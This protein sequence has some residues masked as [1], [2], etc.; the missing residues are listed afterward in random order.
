MGSLRQAVRA[1]IPFSADIYES[2]DRH[3]R[4]RRA[5]P[6]IDA[7]AAGTTPIKLDLGGGYRKGTNG[8]TTVDISHECDLFWDLRH[9]IPFADGTVAA[10]YSSHLFEHLTYEQGQGLMRESLR[11]L[12]PRGSFSIV[13]PNAKLYIEHYMGARDLPDEFFTWEPAFHDSTRIDALNYIAYMAGEHTYM[14]DIE[15]LLFRMR[16]AGFVDVAERGFDPVTDM[17]ERDYES[18]YAIGYA[19]TN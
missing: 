10:V 16:A 11:V 12:R 14:F 5:R 7:M 13:V 17:A 2:I 3:L 8:W 4:M 1:K 15:N 9:G 18:I 19:P 6:R